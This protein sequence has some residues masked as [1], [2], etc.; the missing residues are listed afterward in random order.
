[1]REEF[2][3]CDICGD[4]F[5]NDSSKWIKVEMKINEVAYEYDVCNKIC[6]AGTRKNLLVRIWRKFFHPLSWE[7]K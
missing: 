6:A 1:M 7:T 3:T 4:Y 5:A 2:I